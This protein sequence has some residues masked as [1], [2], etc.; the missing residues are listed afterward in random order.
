MRPSIS[1]YSSALGTRLPVTARDRLAHLVAGQ[2][3]AVGL[4]ERGDDDVGDPRD[5]LSLGPGDHPCFDDLA[6][7]GCFGGV[8][9]APVVFGVQLGFDL[10]AGAVADRHHD[11]GQLPVFRRDLGAVAQSHQGCGDFQLAQQPVPVER[12]DT[13]IAA[14]L[15]ARHGVDGLGR[16]RRDLQDAQRGAVDGLS[17][18]S[19]SFWSMSSKNAAMVL[20]GSVPLFSPPGQVQRS[21]AVGPLLRGAGVVDREPDEPLRGS[22]V[23]IVEQWAGAQRL[24][25][26]DHAQPVPTRTRV[27]LLVEVGRGNPET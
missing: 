7:A 20:L 15:P 5:V 23:D 4:G 22:G 8:E 13:T 10:C 9:I 2:C 3:V 21:C 25:A 16:F 24:Y 6:G 11:S 14:Q 19:A 12:V 26:D 18:W 17:S 27:V 1:R